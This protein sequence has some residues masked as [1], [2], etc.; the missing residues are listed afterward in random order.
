L[1]KIWTAPGA[2]PPNAPPPQPPTPPS[3]HVIEFFF[4]FNL[5]AHVD[6]AFTCGIALLSLSAAPTHNPILVASRNSH[7]TRSAAARFSP[8]SRLAVKTVSGASLFSVGGGFCCVPRRNF[9]VASGVAASGR[10]PGA[11]ATPP[12]IESGSRLAAEAAVNQRLSSSSQKISEWWTRV[13]R[14]HKSY[15][16]MERE[17]ASS[18]GGFSLCYQ[19]TRNIS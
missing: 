2:P 13:L 12:T 18:G 4:R 1:A 5:K 14:P 16:V 7:V 9:S 15:H 17:D 3:L 19:P 10:V 8:L 11:I 6:S